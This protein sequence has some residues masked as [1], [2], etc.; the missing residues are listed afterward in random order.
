[1]RQPLRRLIVLIAVALAACRF[2]ATPAAI[3]TPPAAPTTAPPSVPAASETLAAT[4]RP[5]TDKPGI[6][7]PATP[8][9]PTP[10]PTLADPRSP[11][12]GSPPSVPDYVTIVDLAFVDPLNGWALG[13]SAG[14]GTHPLRWALIYRT[15]D[16][17]QH[18]DLVAAPEAVVHAAKVAPDLPVLNR[19]RFSSLLAGEL[20]GTHHFVTGDGGRTWQDA[21]PYDPAL[22]AVALEA[23]ALYLAEGECGIDEGSGYAVCPYALQAAGGAAQ[24]GWP[25]FEAIHGVAL[26]AAGP[27]TAWIAYSTPRGDGTLDTTGHLLRTRDGGQTWAALPELPMTWSPQG[28]WGFWFVPVDEQTIWLASGNAG[29][30]AF[31]GKVAYVSTDGG[32]SWDLRARVAIDGSD[33]VGEIQV[34]GYLLDFEAAS[35][36]RAF[37][38]MGWVPF[39]GTSDGGR[40][41]HDAIPD[42]L[43]P[44]YD[45]ATGPIVFIDER[46]GW[47]VTGDAIFRTADG[48]DTWEPGV[49]P[50]LPVVTPIPPT[51][52]AGPIPS[53]LPSA[54]WP[55]PPPPTPPP[56]PSPT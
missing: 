38:A 36:E 35:A 9:T 4:E 34:V 1:M 33:P 15:G 55:Y 5:D 3:D 46:H 22:E 25:S 41:W 26:I 24:P 16:G 43:P 32:E 47:A 50:G 54:T 37:I 17:G 49:V 30:G 52:T 18:W 12:A 29:A 10:L 44:G 45:R 20:L 2:Q 8:T 21:G 48:G 23:G 11:F 56:S 13:A 40:T 6:S 31:G 51:P 39:I 19:L 28:G 14:A 53:P 42:F 7:E 27:R